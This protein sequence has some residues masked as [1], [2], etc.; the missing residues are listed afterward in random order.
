MLTRVLNWLVL[1]PGPTP[2]RTSR[3]SSYATNSPSYA[4]QPRTQPDLG[5]P[6]AT[7][8]TG[9]TPPPP[10]AAT[11]DRHAPN[12]AGLGLPPPPHTPPP[13]PAAATPDRHAP[14][15]A[16]LAC[17]PRQTTLD[18]PTTPTRTTTDNPASP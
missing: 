7:H 5:R 18:L 17:A 3:S 2:P 4:A 12:P 10:A 9:S 14:N 6:R 1:L 16:A 13:P 11:P 15:P 8:R